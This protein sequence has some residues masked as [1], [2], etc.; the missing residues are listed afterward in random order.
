MIWQ[1][2]KD[3]LQLDTI[4]ADNKLLKYPLM[5]NIP[6]E[7]LNDDVGKIY[8]ITEIKFESFVIELINKKTPQDFIENIYPNSINADDLLNG[9]WFDEV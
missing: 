5:P 1:K 3:K 8:R 9:Q 7:L 6:D 4:K 2:I